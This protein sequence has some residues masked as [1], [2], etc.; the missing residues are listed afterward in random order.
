MKQRYLIFSLFTLLL[1]ISITS[2]QETSGSKPMAPSGKLPSEA[3][4]GVING[5]AVVLPKPEYSD[6]LKTLCA[7][8]EVKLEVHVSESGSVLEAVDISGDELLHEPSI[9]A[10]KEARFQ[11][12]H[13]KPVPY[14]GIVVYN[15]PSEK[16]CV[17]AGI[18]NGKWIMRPSFSL[19]PHAKVTKPTVISIRIG[20][21]PFSGNVR[22]AK[23]ANG[24]PLIR[25]TLEQ[26]ARGIRFHPS[27][28]NSKPF[29]VKGA[30]TVTI[31]PNGKIT[32]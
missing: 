29:I 13:G 17:D 16:T 2:A 19:H 3:A 28:I 30:I 10:V 24:H 27:L 4:R 15:F 6:E 25:R 31:L 22:A 9:A 26:Q 7:S 14:D 5:R 21:D 20:I 11:P 1:A 32:F 8:G 23:A 12:L 18:V